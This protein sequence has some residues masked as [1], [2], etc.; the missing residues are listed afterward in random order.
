[1][2]QPFLPLNLDR[3]ATP[4]GKE[5]QQRLGNVEDLLSRFMASQQNAANAAT[6]AL[7]LLSKQ[8]QLLEAEANVQ[9]NEW[10]NLNGITG[11]TGFYSPAVA[12]VQIS[13]PSGRIEVGF[14]GSLNSGNGYFCYSVT[15]AKS[16][17]VVAASTV[18]QNYAERVAVS[19]GASFTASAFNTVLVNV[20]ANEVMTVKVELYAASSMTYFFGARISARV[21]P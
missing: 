6:S 11:F 17:T 2:A 4:A 5:L 9:Y 18:Q 21:T 14:G 15:G 8:V 1:M 20:P 7:A 13:S 12:S 19:G 10:Q 3:N 16:G